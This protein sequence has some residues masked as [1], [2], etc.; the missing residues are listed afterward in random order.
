M[1]RQLPDTDLG[2]AEHAIELGA[3]E[4]F[5]LGCGLNLDDSALPGHHEVGIRLNIRILLVVE[6]AEA[7]E[8]LNQR[9]DQDAGEVLDTVATAAEELRTTAQ[10]MSSIA[11]YRCAKMAWK[12]ILPAMRGRNPKYCAKP[13]T[14][15]KCKKNCKTCHKLAK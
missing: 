8:G 15:N 10:S 2:E 14:P 6:E 12:C 11:S 4:G 3:A 13:R 7:I 5:V 9:F 1:G